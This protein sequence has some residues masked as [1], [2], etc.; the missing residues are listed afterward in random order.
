MEAHIKGAAH[1]EVQNGEIQGNLHSVTSK[2]LDIDDDLKSSSATSMPDYGGMVQDMG[3]GAE[4]ALVPK[5]PHLYLDAPEWDLEQKQNG[6]PN[7]ILDMDLSSADAP[8]KPEKTVR[9]NFFKHSNKGSGGLPDK[10]CKYKAY[11]PWELMQHI[12]EEHHKISIETAKKLFEELWDKN[13][14]LNDPDFTEINTRESGGKYGETPH[15]KNAEK[16]CQK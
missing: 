12:K 16:V 1:I 4:E 8:L 14:Q 3:L 9:C 13:E 15:Y 5:V 6:F 11:N 7:Y 2:P 10:D